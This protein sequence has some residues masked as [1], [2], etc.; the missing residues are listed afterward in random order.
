MIRTATMEIINR[1][2]CGRLAIDDHVVTSARRVLTEHRDSTTF[3]R[4]NRTVRMEFATTDH[5]HGIKDSSPSLAVAALNSLRNAERIRRS[6]TFAFAAMGLREAIPC[7]RASK[8]EYDDVIH[9][10]TH[11]TRALINFGGRIHNSHV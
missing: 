8:C 4:R 6:G 2:G 3:E 11:R 9:S 1:T 7:G 10:R 5:D